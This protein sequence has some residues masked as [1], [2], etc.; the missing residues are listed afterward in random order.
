[1]L[2]VSSGRLHWACNHTSNEYTFINPVSAVMPSEPE[3]TA[4][5]SRAATVAT[6]FEAKVNIELVFD[7]EYACS[8]LRLGTAPI[9]FQKLPYQCLAD[10]PQSRGRSLHCSSA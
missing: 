10:E 6:V 2:T 5:Y 9:L 8:R 4:L 3:S 7:V 1:M